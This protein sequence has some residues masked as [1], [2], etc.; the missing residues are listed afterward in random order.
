MISD[1]C[2]Q[3]LIVTG[4]NESRVESAAASSACARTVLYSLLNAQLQSPAG[5][6][7]ERKSWF[8]LSS[9]FLFKAY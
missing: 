6:N 9:W 3:M 5:I 7:G 4:P 1:R 8:F 2:W